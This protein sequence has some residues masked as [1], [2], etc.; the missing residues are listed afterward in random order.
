MYQGPPLMP[1]T[2]SEEEELRQ[3]RRAARMQRK[4]QRRKARILLTTTVTSCVVLIALLGFFFLRLQAALNPTY[5]PINGITCDPGMHATYHI[6]VHL[7][8]YIKGNPVTIPQGIGIPSSGNCYYWLHTHT[9]DGIVHIEAPSTSDNW[10]AL[11]DFI[12]IWHNGFASLNFPSQLE[13]PGWRLYLNGQ[14][15]TATTTPAKAEIR[16]RS[17]DLITLEYQAP[18]PPPERPGTYV[19]PADLPQ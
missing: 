19:F 7:A 14:P 10:L 1:P 8:I 5:P 18:Y 2:I 3:Q 15:F 9:S 16:F 11:D 13:Q 12:A 4:Q 17:H 6:H